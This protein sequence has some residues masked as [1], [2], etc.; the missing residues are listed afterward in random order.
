MELLSDSYPYMPLWLLGLLFFAAL[1]VARE[2]GFALRRR[3]SV[4]PGQGEDTFAMTSVLG[5]LALLI[6]FTFSLASHRYDTR[7][8]LVVQ[9]A[10]ALGT[11]W[12]RTQLVDSPGREA[13][14]RVLLRYVAAR[15]TY[16]EARNAR[17]ENAAYATTES[18]Q[19]ES[20]DVLME[21]VA[22]FRDTPRA[23]LLVTT[24]N[25]SIDLAATRQA[26]RQAHIPPRILRLLALFAIVSA[27]MVG[28]ERG[29]QRRATTMLFVLLTLAV[30][31]VLDLDRPST[32]ILNV[33]QQPLIDLQRSLTPSQIGG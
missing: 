26:M 24:M 6:A 13:L 18:L 32:G 17:A 25:E 2:I 22:P 7:R 1:L 4:V 5:L 10:N 19:A 3:R 15:V 30:T 9:E 16:G 27:A 12:L 23:S 31:L 29:A 28:Y 8:E 14:Q 20:W 33:P 21:V 11:T